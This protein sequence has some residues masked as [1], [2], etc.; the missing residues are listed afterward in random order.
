VRTKSSNIKD[1]LPSKLDIIESVQQVEYD[2]FAFEIHDDC[3]EQD[4]S[5][6]Q[7]LPSSY[8]FHSSCAKFKKKNSKI[9]ILKE[10]IQEYV[11]LDR[12]MKTKSE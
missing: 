12:H 9:K 2:P 1:C 8:V 3:M 4:T 6:K 5:I 11:I 7:Q 10:E